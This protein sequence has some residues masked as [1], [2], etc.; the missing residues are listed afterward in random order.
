MKPMTFIQKDMFAYTQRVHL[1]LTCAFHDQMQN[2][3]PRLFSQPN[4]KKKWHS[5]IRNTM[6]EKERHERSYANGMCMRIHQT[7]NYSIH[8][9]CEYWIKT[10]PSFK[11]ILW[12]QSHSAVNHLY[13]ILYMRE[14]KRAKKLFFFSQLN[15]NS[16]GTEKKT[17]WKLLVGK[18]EFYF[19]SLAYITNHTQRAHMNHTYRNKNSYKDMVDSEC[20]CLI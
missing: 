15:G 12:T 7:I 16:E 11:F 19:S 10:M 3:I 4:S 13:T 9:A 14:S 18:L 2:S 5:Q 8:I 1:H 20:V 6:R 17:G